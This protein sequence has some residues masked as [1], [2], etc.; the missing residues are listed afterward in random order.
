MKN[1][2]ATAVFALTILGTAEAGSSYDTSDMLQ[3]KRDS[4]REI[5]RQ[6]DE[7]VNRESNHY[8]GNW[9]TF[10]GSGMSYSAG[11]NGHGCTTFYGGNGNPSST[12][13]D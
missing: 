12:S 7:V 11:P 6:L 1:I 13:C 4:D 2:I 3:N 8:S 9:T 10:Y 5:E